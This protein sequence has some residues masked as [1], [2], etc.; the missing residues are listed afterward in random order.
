MRVLLL[1]L[2]L[3]G[4][5]VPVKLDVGNPVAVASCPERLP[6]QVND[7]FGGTVEKLVEVA[8]IYHKCRAAAVGAK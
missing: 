7:T 3:A 4:C 1:C 6:P 5:S 8:G 2:L